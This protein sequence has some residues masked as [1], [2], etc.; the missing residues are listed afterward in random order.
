V[1]CVPME[2]EQ[3]IINLLRNAAQAMAS[4]PNPPADPRIILRLR[5]EGKMAVIEVDD[6][7]PGIAEKDR[8]KVFEPFYTTK[9][10]GEGTGL[11]LSVSYF[12][13]T[14]NHGGTIRVE[15]EPG[16]G[17]KFIIS[18]PMLSGVKQDDADSTKPA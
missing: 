3:V 2:I 7:G 6:N 10:P 8:R 1:P 14:R 18:L 17:A 9:K 4:H 11:G 15:S 12:I 13:I 16:K 5:A